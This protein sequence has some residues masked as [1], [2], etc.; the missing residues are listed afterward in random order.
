MSVKGSYTDFH[1]D[2]GGSSVWCVNHPNLVLGLLFGSWLKLSFPS[3]PASLE[4]V[5]RALGQEGV[6]HD[7]TH[8][9][10]S[11]AIREVGDFAVAGHGFPG[12]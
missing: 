7:R 6:L 3:P 8:P 9:G 10:E 4:Q 12:Q 1:I 2:F 5:P 11:Q